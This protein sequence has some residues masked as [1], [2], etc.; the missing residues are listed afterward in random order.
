MTV[1]FNGLENETV[2][3][4]T[5]NSVSLTFNIPDTNKYFNG[6]FPGYP[7]LPAVAQMEIVVRFAKKYLGTTISVSQIKR[8]KFNTI[9]SPL[10]T[11]ML[12]LEKMMIH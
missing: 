4:K 11:V 10:V 3:D 6:H 8:M 12:K 5:A 2:L 7:I 1:G 9:I